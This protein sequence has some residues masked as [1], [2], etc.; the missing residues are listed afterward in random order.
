MK[1]S[2]KKFV[3]FWMLISFFSACT[4]VKWV[5]VERLQ[6]AQ[7]QVP[8]LVRRVAVVNNQPDLSDKNKYSSDLKALDGKLVA[9]SLA[10][11]LADAAYFEEV[12]VYDSVLATE[13][14]LVCDERELSPGQVMRLARELQVDML[15]SVEMAVLLLEYPCQV[16]SV[17]KLYLPGELHPIDTIRRQQQLYPE[18]LYPLEQTPVQEAA[19]LPLSSL[20]PQ[21][22]TVDFPFYTG[23]NVEMRDAAV[24]VAEGNWPA[25]GELWKKLLHHKNPRRRMEANLNMAVWHEVNDDSITVARSYAEK[26]L[27]LAARKMKKDAKGKW[28]ERTDDYLFISAYLRELEQRGRKLEQLKGQMQRFSDDF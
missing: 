5:S 10:Q 6:P 25:A 15:V 17:I 9:D 20:V 16:F 18:E 3:G 7:T 2:L 11:Y 22:Q 14:V 19:F 23:A 24:Y 8:D 4:T 26:A 12:V 27:Q 13:P 28:I 1:Q 21:W